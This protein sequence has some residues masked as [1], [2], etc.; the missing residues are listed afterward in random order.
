MHEVLVVGMPVSADE[1]R[2]EL[3]VVQATPLTRQMSQSAKKL[4]ADHLVGKKLVGKTQRPA[5]LEGAALHQRVDE[6][7]R[8][9]RVR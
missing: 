9:D 2:T 3:P 7:R 6:A 8:L 1:V 5:V 4:V